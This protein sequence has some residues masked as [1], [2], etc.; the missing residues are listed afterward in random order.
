MLPVH[1]GSEHT[2]TLRY[3]V[4][5]RSGGRLVWKG[6]L[7]GGGCDRELPGT[8]VRSNFRASFLRTVISKRGGFVHVPVGRAQDRSAVP[9]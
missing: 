6:R 5:F 4:P 7:R 2:L 9:S 1:I 8:W 3:L